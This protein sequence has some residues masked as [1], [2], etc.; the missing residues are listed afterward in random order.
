MN[1]HTRWFSGNITPSIEG[2]YQRQRN[3]VVIYS[4][5]DGKKWM[6]GGDSVEVCMELRKWEAFHQEALWRGLC[7]PT[8]EQ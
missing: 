6:S 7:Q 1:N 8:V 5:W 2:V 4:Y 3:G